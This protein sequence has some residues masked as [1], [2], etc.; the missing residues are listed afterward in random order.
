[1][2]YEL[3]LSS[4]SCRL[5]DDAVFIPTG[6]GAHRIFTSRRDPTPDTNH[7]STP[8][9]APP[10]PTLTPA[11]NRKGHLTEERH[12]YKHVAVQGHPILQTPPR[13]RPT[14]AKP[15]PSPGVAFK[16]KPSEREELPEALYCPLCGHCVEHGVE[17]SSSRAESRFRE[18]LIQVSSS[19]LSPLT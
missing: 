2:N 5:P 14:P 3:F 9:A 7:L 8:S 19:P 16:K 15:S 13:S 6:T 18:H 12:E 11:S 17:D 1:V 4:P 10:I